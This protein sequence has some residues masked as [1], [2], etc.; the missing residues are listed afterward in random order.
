MC[1][2][3]TIPRPLAGYELVAPPLLWPE[4]VSSLRE[5]AW[6][7]AL[8][9]DV[10]IQAVARVAEMDVAIVA[11]SRLPATAYEIAAS[12]GWAKTYDAEY[13]ALARL[14]GVPFLTRDGRLRRGA[15]RVVDFFPLT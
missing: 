11:D 15:S 7:G 5:T 13:L 4:T 9:A 10:A 1:V 2:L 3:G 14:L 12:L 8:S 6:R